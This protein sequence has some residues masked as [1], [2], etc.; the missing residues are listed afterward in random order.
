M[1]LLPNGVSIQAASVDNTIKKIQD[2]FS[3]LITT[4]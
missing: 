1:I 4:W 2:Y 3:L